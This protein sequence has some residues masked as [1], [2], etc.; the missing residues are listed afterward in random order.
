MYKHKTV[1]LPN[2][3]YNKEQL[4]QV[5]YY[6]KHALPLSYLWYRAQVSISMQNLHRL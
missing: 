4:R 6:T 2:I 5:E 3:I 1:I